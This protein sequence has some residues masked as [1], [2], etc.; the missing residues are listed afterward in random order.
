LRNNYKIYWETIL[1]LMAFVFATMLLYYSCSE[2]RAEASETPNP[3]ER[4]ILHV[5]TVGLPKHKISPCPAH[6]IAHNK[7]TRLELVA[8]IEDASSA[9]RIDPYFLVAIGFRENRFLPEEEGALGERGVFQMIPAV[10][11]RVRTE[12]DNRC[13]LDTVR[14][15]AFC[16]AAWLDHWRSKCNGCLKGAFVVYASGQRVCKPY[17]KKLRWMVQ[18]R[19]GIAK[20]LR[21]VTAPS[22]E[23]LQARL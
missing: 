17:S 22:T 12:M 23:V 9:Y 15:S 4:A 16:T 19:F 11:K 1:T 2:S 8:A 13:T 6:P 10:A 21:Q 18:D 14:G 3:V 7:Y 20:R 5:V